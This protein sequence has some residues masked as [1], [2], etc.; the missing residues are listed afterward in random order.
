MGKIYV[1][2]TALTIRLTTS[3]DLS[4]AKTVAIKYLKPSGET[5][6][7][8][9]TIYSVATGVISY[10]IASSSILDESGV[11]TFWAFITFNDDTIALGEPVRKLIYDEGK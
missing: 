7:W 9:A 8:T 2:Q 5:G 10:T 1:G 11:W 6:T 3:I 4:T